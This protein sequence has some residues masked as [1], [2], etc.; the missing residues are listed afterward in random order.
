MVPLRAIHVHGRARNRNLH[1]L[2]PRARGKGDQGG[3][4]DHE[5]ARTGRRARRSRRGWR[6]SAVRAP[7][8]RPPGNAPAQRAFSTATTAQG[9]RRGSFRPGRWSPRCHLPSPNVG[10]HEIGE[11]V[12]SPEGKEGEWISS[13]KPGSFWKRPTSKRKPVPLSLHHLPKWRSPPPTEPSRR[14]LIPPTDLLAENSPRLLPF[15]CLDLHRKALPVFR[16]HGERP[17]AGI[18]G[19]LLHLRESI[20]LQHAEQKLAVL[21]AEAGEGLSRS[22]AARRKT[23]PSFSLRKSSRP[24]ESV[25]NDRRRPAPP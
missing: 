4:L 7:R 2:V 6:R 10:E 15:L 11:A 13:S 19:N 5:D 9:T 24:L 3:R 18:R 17:S 16:P 1:H 12:V 8:G 20:L 25:G 21:H 22:F 14:E 23:P